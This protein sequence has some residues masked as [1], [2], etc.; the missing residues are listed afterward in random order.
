MQL[1]NEVMMEIESIVT[2][3]GLEL[4]HV[5]YKPMGR[6]MLLRIDVDR[7]GGV[8]LDDCESIARQVGTWLDVADPIPS[9]YELQVSSPGLDRKFYGE[10]D[11]ER[12][13]GS[14]VRV[15]TAEM[16]GGLHVIIGRLTGFDGSR[17]TVVDTASKK[18][19]EYVI[20][21]DNVKETRL[22]PEI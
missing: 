19:K 15:K 4:V 11:Y 3:E 21:L 5:D 2:G 22:E 9:R 17:L 16:V 7:E 13:V 8:T 6:G 20:E 1:P 10:A 12:F 14:L 18:Q